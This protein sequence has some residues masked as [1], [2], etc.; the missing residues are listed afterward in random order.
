[1]PDPDDLKRAVD[2]IA[3][4]TAVDG[5]TI[6]NDRYEVLAFGAKIMRRRGSPQ[7]EQVNVTEPVEGSVADSRD[8]GA[9][10]RHAPPV[11]GAVHPRSARRHGAGGVA[12]RPLH[13]LQVVAARAVRARASGGRAVAVDARGQTLRAVR[14]ASGL[15][16]GVRPLLGSDPCSGQTLAG[17]YSGWSS[18]TSP[19]S[20]G[21]ISSGTA[22]SISSGGGSNPSCWAMSSI[23]GRSFRSFRPK[24]IR[25]SLVVP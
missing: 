15:M 20:S 16:L 1:M 12:G 3:G 22:R 10:G 19:S 14:R 9:T 2:A 5:A 11:G 23:F 13:H 21:S 8:A 17:S 18:G 4:L 7:V 6:I 24:R 25:N